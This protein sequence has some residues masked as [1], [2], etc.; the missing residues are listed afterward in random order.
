MEHLTHRMAVL[1]EQTKLA[2]VTDF[3]NCQNRQH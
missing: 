2:A 1:R 3:Q